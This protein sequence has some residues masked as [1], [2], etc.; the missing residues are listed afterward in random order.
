MRLFFLLS[1][2][3][4]STV[5]VK[6]QVQYTAGPELDNDRDVKVNRMLGGDDNSF[7]CYRIRS[8]GRG[9]SYFVEKY[10]KKKL[11]PV[12]S[13]EVILDGD[14][15]KS[16][17]EN[18]LYAQNTVYIFRRK[19]DKDGDKMTLY[20]QSVSSTGQVSE[21]LTPVFTVNADH[22]EFVDF[23]VYQN[24]A[25]TKFI[26][27]ASHKATKDADYTTDFVL[28]DGKDLSKIWTKTVK[29]RLS[30]QPAMGFSFMGIGSSGKKDISLVGLSFDDKD[31]I[32]YCYTDEAEGSTKKDKHYQL[33]MATFNAQD[34]EPKTV[35]LKFDDEY[36]INDIEFLKTGDNEMVVAGYVKDVVERRGRDL[37]KVGFFSYKVN[38]GANAVSAKAVF[39]FDDKMLKALESSPKR[40]RY[41]K[42]KLDYI[43]PIGDAVYYVGEQYNEEL[44]T[45]YSST[46]SSSSSYWKYEYM[47]VIVTKLN[48]NGQFDWT[49]N[50]PLRNNLEMP[51]SHVFKQYIAVPT[52]KSLYIL[53]ND[54]PKNMA[55]YE[56]DDYEPSDLKTVEKIHG[57]NFVSNQVDLA[58]GGIKRSV[59]FENDKYCFAPIQERNPAFI[60][61][62]ECEIFVPGNNDEVYIYTEDRG[63]DQFGKL[64]LKP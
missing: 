50:V 23:D 24:P 41:F 52:E 57:T 55:R 10:D 33:F 37:I 9:T 7:Y 61:P 5:F 19:Y 22:Y 46:G 51:F 30:N 32:Y 13:K 60:P 12:F 38:L 25:K 20:Y 43:L 56:K 58:K 21:K 34:K 8:R 29:H 45:R 62:S 28:L 54:H 16:R 47:D 64:K 18:V 53:C 39:F 27:K 26:V 1:F 6:A 42:Y 48:A 11:Q 40:S 49:K 2:T 36:L 59:V 3:L 4:L 31:N 63:R 44:V 15:L 17:V 14:D 35:E